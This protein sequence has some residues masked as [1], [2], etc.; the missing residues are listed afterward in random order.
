MINTYIVPKTLIVNVRT[1]SM[2]SSSPQF[3]INDE[4]ENQVEGSGALTR[5]DNGW[6]I[7]GDD[8]E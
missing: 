7:W 6:D 5:E 8:M 4:D 1:Q 3:N 2:I